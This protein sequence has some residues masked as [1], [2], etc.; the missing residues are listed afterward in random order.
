MLIATL[1]PLIR[2]LAIHLLY[3]LP[4]KQLSRLQSQSLTRAS[5]LSPV[6]SSN[7]STPLE[8]HWLKQLQ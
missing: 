3:S 4:I 1:Q 2:L 7:F 5:R 8:L 6:T